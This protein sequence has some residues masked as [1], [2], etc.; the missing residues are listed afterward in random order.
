MKKIV[1]LLVVMIL[2]LGLN[3]NVL[4]R[5]G[6]VGGLDMKMDDNIGT[7]DITGPF[8]RLP[9]KVVSGARKIAKIALYNQIGNAKVE[10]WANGPALVTR[11]KAGQFVSVSRNQADIDKFNKAKV[12]KTRMDALGF[13]LGVVSAPKQIAAL[14]DGKF[15]AKQDVLAAIGLTS[16]AIKGTSLAAKGV[17]ALAAG[18]KFASGAAKVGSLASKASRI[19][20]PAGAIAGTLFSAVDAYRAAKEKGMG[21]EEFK[22]AAAETAFG[23][24]GVAAFFT[25]PPVNLALGIISVGGTLAIQIYKNREALAKGVKNL[26]EKGKALAEKVGSVVKGAVDNVSQAAGNMMKELANQAAQ[27]KANVTE[28]VKKAVGTLKDNAVKLGV[29]ATEF[30]KATWEKAKEAVGNAVDTA[31]TAVQNTVNTVANGASQAFNTVKDAVGNFVGGLF[32]GGN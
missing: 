15:D 21:S 27:W 19:L 20:G 10:Q 5:G 22:L 29:K 23:A 16:T 9:L 11:N 6:S 18:S 30:A 26:C 31:K 14:T 1:R 12:W 17:Q 8:L 13:A 25:P 3:V 2:I 28:D 4:A 32:G 7:E 24:I